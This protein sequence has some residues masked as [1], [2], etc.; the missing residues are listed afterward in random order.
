MR[1]EGF[2]IRRAYFRNTG[3]G[4][5]SL[6]PSTGS[7]PVAATPN[8]TRIPIVTLAGKSAPVLFSGL[9]NGAV[10][11]YVVRVLVPQDAASG[12]Q[13]ELQLTISGFASNMVTLAIE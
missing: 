9:A 2:I 3:L 1:Q 10:G 7:N 12:S 4:S 13:V 6:A 5:V 8:L 11:A